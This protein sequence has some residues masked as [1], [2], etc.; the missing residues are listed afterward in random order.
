MLV[1]R[2][3]NVGHVLAETGFVVLQLLGA[4][5]IEVCKCLV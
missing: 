5:W 4:G 1:L 3:S 2:I